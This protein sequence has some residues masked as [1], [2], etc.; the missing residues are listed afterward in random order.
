[1]LNASWRPERTDG[2]PNEIN[3][4]DALYGFRCCH[5]FFQAAD[6][7]RALYVTGVQTCALPISIRGHRPPPRREWLPASSRPS[8][9]RLQRRG[10]RKSACRERV[11]ITEATPTEIKQ[12]DARYG[13]RCC[14]LKKI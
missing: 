4:Y 8:S 3:Q 1:Y 5:F 13:F 11:D 12:D 14:N 9:T 10:D 7:I 2:N 6:G